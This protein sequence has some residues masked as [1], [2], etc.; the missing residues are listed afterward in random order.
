MK[1]SP[2]SRWLDCQKGNK[3][4]QRYGVGDIAMLYNPYGSPFKVKI[5]ACIQGEDGSWYYEVT[6]ISSREG[7]REVPQKA[8]TPLHE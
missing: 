1:K 7:S 8:L 6:P 2:V 3:M 5:E 4:N